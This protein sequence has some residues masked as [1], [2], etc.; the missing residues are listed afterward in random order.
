MPL[1]PLTVETRPWRSALWATGALVLALSGSQ[2][3]ALS[4]GRVMVQSA[5]GEPLR[6][7]IDFLDISAEEATSLR[8][9]VAS[10]E[11]FRAAGLSYNASVIGLQASLQKRADGRLYIQLASSVAITDSFFDLLLEA[12]WAS[13][14][15]L[16]DYTLLFA[17]AKVGAT[18]S[19]S[20]ARIQISNGR[21]KSKAPKVEGGSK[22]K[23]RAGNT[24]SEIA[25]A[26]KP[27]NVSLDQMLVAL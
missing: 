15:I 17:P 25:L 19:D 7:E 11:A 16:R 21:S 2:A 20:D 6:A 9:S 13:G 23:V 1:T 12:S 8:T 26:L 4:L 5:L 3:L 24:A 18:Q 10:P 27:A 22:V 14:R